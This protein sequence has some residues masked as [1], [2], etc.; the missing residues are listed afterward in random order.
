METWLRL[1]GK[2]SG[3]LEAGHVL[4]LP[5]KPLPKNSVSPGIMHSERHLT[6]K[7]TGGILKLAMI[8]GRPLQQHNI[9]ARTI[10]SFWHGICNEI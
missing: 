3:L 5:F 6:M 2:G 7:E 9:G 8:P 10:F 1:Q 4:K